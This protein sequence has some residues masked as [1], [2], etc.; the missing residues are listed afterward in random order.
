MNSR[1]KGNR[2]ERGA[3]SLITA[4]TS[5]KFERT[6]SSGGLQWKSSFSKGDI[7]CTVEG[8]RFPFCVEV[9]AHKEIDFSHLLNP[10]IKNI[11][12]IEFWE[13]C[14][15]DA[16]SCN[17][18]PLLMMRY[19]MMPKDFFFIGIPIP[20]FACL[21]GLRLVGTTNLSYKGKY[22]IMFMR[23]DEFFGFNYKEVKE[24]AKQYL[25][26]IKEKTN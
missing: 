6:P 16:T 1:N 4:W 2:N 18:I 13:Q 7:V 20:F 25:N 23:S 9:K 17:K 11:K 21:K 15:R 8:H 24:L 22:N 14:L 26:G 5:K 3:A 12:I 19:D 10:K